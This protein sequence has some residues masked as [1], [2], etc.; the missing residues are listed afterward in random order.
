MLLQDTK[1]NEESGVQYLQNGKHLRI[2]ME[3]PQLFITSYSD[4]D[5]EHCLSL[6]G[7]ENL[8]RYFDHGKPRSRSEI[9]ELIEIKGHQYFRQGLPFGLFSLFE[10]KTNVFIGQVDL[11]PTE[12]Q[13][14]IEVGY[15]LQSEYQN[16]GLCTEAINALLKFAKRIKENFPNLSINKIIAT[17]HPQ[18]TASKRVLEKVGMKYEK[19][20]LR[21]GQPRI[22]YSI[23]IL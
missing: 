23:D 16:K 17:F 11:L 15:I 13:G 4:Q 6:Y 18:N 7:D 14:E 1:L 10:K 22:L 8:T 3:S 20:L 2:E 19:S 9:R 21:F 12:R 5:F